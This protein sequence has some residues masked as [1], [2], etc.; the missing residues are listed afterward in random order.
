MARRSAWNQTR[1]SAYLLSR[2][3]GDVSAA[4]RGPA[5]LAKRLVRRSIT[6]SLFRMLRSK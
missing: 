3:M 6:R 5:P 2:D 1:R 4:R